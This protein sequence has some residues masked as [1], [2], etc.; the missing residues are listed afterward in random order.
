MDGRSSG[1]GRS[2]AAK[3]HG[4]YA[5]VDARLPAR[6]DAGPGTSGMVQLGEAILGLADPPAKGGRIVST[7]VGG[8][9]QRGGGTDGNGELLSRAV[10]GHHVRRNGRPEI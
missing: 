8:R 5:R 6:E 1:V 4:R 10:A 2:L 7:P 3:R 9:K